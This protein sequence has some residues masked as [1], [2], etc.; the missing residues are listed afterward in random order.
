MNIDSQLGHHTVH[1]DKHQ[2][3]KPATVAQEG[4]HSLDVT[5]VDWTLNEK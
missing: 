1:N 2:I 4:S 5:S 3:P